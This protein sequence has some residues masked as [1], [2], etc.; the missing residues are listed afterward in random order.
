MS[1]HR[2]AAVALHGLAE[3]DRGLILAQLP[4]ADQSTLRTYLAELTALGFESEGMAEVAQ[5]GVGATG[6]VEPTLDRASA[7]TMFALLEHEPASLVAQ[8]LAL[9]TWAWSGALL[10]LCTPARRE[11]IRAVATPAAPARAQFLRAELVARLADLAPVREAVV[12]TL[13][14]GF[15][16][17]LVSAWTR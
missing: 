4:P 16:R 5:A 13:S 6:S 12:G 7:Q 15:L 3:E 9:Q 11:A 10:A 8:V 14:R 1:G 2:Q 17:R